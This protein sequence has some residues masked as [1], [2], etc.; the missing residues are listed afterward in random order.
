MDMSYHTGTKLY[1]KYLN[2][3]NHNIP[4]PYIPKKR[5][6]AYTQEE[7]N[8]CISYIVDDKMTMT[9][10]SKKANIPGACGSRYYRMYINDPNRKIPSPSD[11]TSSRVS[12]RLNK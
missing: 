4:A 6:N 8:K 12:S 3:P 1:Q 9:V 2:D 11:P 7:I 5:T 10:A